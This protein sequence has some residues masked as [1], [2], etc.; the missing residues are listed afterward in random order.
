MKIAKNSRKVALDA[1]FSVVVNKKSL[2]D[3]DFDGNSFATSLSFGVLRFYHHLNKVVFS[4]LKKDFN[5]EDLDIF[6]ILLLG[7]YQIIYED[8]PNFAAI[9]ESVNLVEKPWARGL[10]NA[11]LRKISIA[12][13]QKSHSHPK[14]LERKIKQQYPDN[15]EDIMEQNNLQAPMTIRVS[16]CVDSY[17]KQL[18][19]VG[20]VSHK[21]EFFD[22]ALV[23]EN[24]TAVGKLP[25]FENGS[26]YI[27][28]ASAQ[29]CGQILTP[30][31]N[32]LILDSCC[33]PGGKTTHLAGLNA[34]SKIIALDN[35]ANRLTR[36]EENIARMRLENIEVK[37]GNALNLDWW[38]GVL[39][40]K[41]LL[42]APCSAT[43]VIR[44]HPDIK[45]LRKATDINKLVLIQEQMLDNLWQTL[46]VGGTFLY[47]TCSI[48]QQENSQ[49]IQRFLD[50]NANCRL[51]KININWGNQNIGIQKLPNADFDGFYY[52]KLKKIK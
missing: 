17:K 46:K 52:A 10:V 48:F 13:I 3:F 43:G 7:S 20:I 35:N 27:Q 47:A 11:I 36:V 15:F 22:K 41:I 34:T 51:K 5:K 26:C 49:Q 8:T 33:A 42:D 50:N 44:R 24:P 30:K 39:F 31:N 38:D 14:W 23:L 1:I 18:E 32:E 9:N 4:F 28:D 16:S 21:L 40:D 25:N 2:S 45:I 29:L 19:E 37:L 6:C 12:D